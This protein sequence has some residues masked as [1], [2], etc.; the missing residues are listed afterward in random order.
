MLCVCYMSGIIIVA[1]PVHCMQ[2]TL[3]LSQS[4][5]TLLDG[6]SYLC[7]FV[8]NGVN[9]TVDAVGSETKYTCNI[10]GRIPIQFQGLSTG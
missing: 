1:T 8:S 6:E 2:L 3:T 9:F 7:H 10:T 5:P 4:L